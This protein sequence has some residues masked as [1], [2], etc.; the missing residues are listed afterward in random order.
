V[1]AFVFLLGMFT[2]MG[3]YVVYILYSESL[4]Q[5][6]KGQTSDLTDRMSRH[7][8]K[9]EKSTKL[10]V[11]WILLW[12]THKETRKEAL[13]LE[14][15]LKNLNRRRTIHL[16]LKYKE[17]IAGTDELQLLLKLSVC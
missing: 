1:L 17:D 2:S 16:M 9:R 5:F 10:G 8:G 11:P 13:L 7:N 4:D 6:Y 12:F 15:K 3:K 14:S